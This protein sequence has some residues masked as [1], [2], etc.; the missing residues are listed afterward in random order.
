MTEHEVQHPASEGLGSPH[1]TSK[2]SV[3]KK[4]PK[5]AKAPKPTAKRAAKAAAQTPAI[6]EASLASEP[7]EGAAVAPPM[8]AAPARKPATLKSTLKDKAAAPSS[9]ETYSKALLA[10]RRRPKANK[11]TPTE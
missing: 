8:K 2:A 6:V 4:S 9:P 3:P 5:V 1:G 7:T 10:K 11:A